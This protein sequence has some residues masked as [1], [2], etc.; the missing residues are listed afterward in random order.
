MKMIG[1]SSEMKIGVIQ[2]SS[3]A[4]KNN[5]LF[6]IVRET[7]K[8][9]ETV[10]FGCYLDE[11][12]QYSYIDI[13]I[14]IG[15]LLNCG[16]V[17]F[18]V[19]G[20]SSGQG[21]ML[22]CNAM[23]GV[24]CG[25]VP[26]PQDAYL[27]GRINNGNAASVPLDL[28]YGWGGEINLKY[29]IEALFSEAFGVGY[30]KEEAERKMRDTNKLKMIKSLSNKSMVTLLDNLDDDTISSVLRRRN[31]VEYIL[32]NGRDHEIIKWIRDENIG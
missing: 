24:L 8:S 18:I 17:D 1:R 22:A 14:E 31:I 16:A 19:T 23:P 12:G 27:F 21:M 25:Y 15:L 29:V 9:H 11:A 32:Q 6:E 20:C 30:P 28:N 4:C 13:S 26:T 5:I 3:Q 2:A 7:A 10:N